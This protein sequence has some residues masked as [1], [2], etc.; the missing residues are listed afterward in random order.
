MNTQEHIDRMLD[1]ALEMTFPASD[2][3]TV[4]MP[5]TKIV[6]DS[7]RGQGRAP[8][9]IKAARPAHRRETC[10][11]NAIA[12]LQTSLRSRSSHESRIY[13][14]D[15]VRVSNIAAAARKRLVTIDDDASLVE[16]A[17]L[18]SRKK[19]SSLIVV[20]D[21]AGGLAG[22]ITKTDIVRQ[23]GRRPNSA[24]TAA[25][26]D[27]MTRDVTCCTP[28]DILENVL[29][30]MTDRGLIHL[31][32]IDGASTP[33][34]V[35]DARDALRALVAQAHYNESLLRNYIIGVGYR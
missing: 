8:E 32:V 1:E 29:A 25:A 21:S 14:M 19:R 34:G 27:V 26:A 4:Y 11:G 33:I 17:R 20:L 7:G 31:P 18:L 5:D 28:D 10:C 24:C 12:R 15:T 23:I 35:L 3:F 2:P 6:Q 30:L 13:T 9:S 22:V 16:A